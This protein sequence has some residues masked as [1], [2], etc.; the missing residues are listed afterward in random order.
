MM[1]LPANG[2]NTSMTQYFVEKPKLNVTVIDGK[3]DDIEKGRPNPD[4]IIVETFDATFGAI[5]VADG[6]LHLDGFALTDLMTWLYREQPATF[7]AFCKRTYKLFPNS[8]DISDLLRA[9]ALVVTGKEHEA[10][11]EDAHF[12]A[13]VREAHPIEFAELRAAWQ[14]QFD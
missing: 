5:H 3:I 11:G 13:K 1:T 2:W 8:S 14:R 9:T 12:C 6:R 10:N 7:K 4:A